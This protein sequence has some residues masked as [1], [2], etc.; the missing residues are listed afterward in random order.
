M[1]TVEYFSRF[2]ESVRWFLMGV[3]GY[4]MTRRETRRN[5]KLIGGTRYKIVK[6]SLLLYKWVG[7]LRVWAL[8]LSPTISDLSRYRRSKNSMWTSWVPSKTEAKWKSR[9]LTGWS[10]SL[11]VGDGGLGGH[12]VMTISSREIMRYIYNFFTILFN[13]RNF[14]NCSKLF[15]IFLF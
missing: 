7:V 2:G 6:V 13:L 4:I 1:N 12:K 8:T 10:L 14:L 3:A 15:E 5:D 11:L 9:D